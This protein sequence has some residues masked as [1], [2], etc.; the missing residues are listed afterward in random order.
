[1][2]ETAKA[3][4]ALNALWRNADDG[5]GILLRITPAGR[6]ALGI[7]PGT[8]DAGIS[9]CAERRAPLQSAAQVAPTARPAQ[10]RPGTKQ[11]LLIGM[12]GRA[13]GANDRRD[14]R[15][16]R[17][18]SRTRCAVRCRAHRRSGWG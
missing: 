6:D 10:T 15:G 14:R 13:E 5:R 12:L 11:A 1:M 9:S 16:P 7:E 3:G 2:E 17:G 4:P 8:T 18:C